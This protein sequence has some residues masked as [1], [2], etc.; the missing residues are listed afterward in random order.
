M[1]SSAAGGGSA[2]IAIG[3]GNRRITSQ[4]GNRVLRQVRVEAQGTVGGSSSGSH[5]IRCTSGN[6]LLELSFKIGFL[7]LDRRLEQK[8]G[9]HATT[10]GSYRV[11]VLQSKLQT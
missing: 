3:T 4:E 11:C 2:P 8:K 6:R 7:V 10:A 1:V 9:D 5:G